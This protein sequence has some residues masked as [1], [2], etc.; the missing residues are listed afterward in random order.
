MN[1]ASVILASASARRLELLAQIGVSCRVVPADIDESRRQGEAPEDYV[2]RLAIAKA[3]AV[4]DSH[5][6]IGLPVLGAD[7]TVVVDNDIFGKPSSETAAVAM[8]QR[9]SG[10]T[11]RVLSAVAMV[12]TK[13]VHHRL[14]ETQVRF[15][16]L[17]AQEC[18]RY[19][20]TAEPLG[21]AGGY[22]IQGRGAVFV[23]AIA[24][25]YSGVVGLPLTETYEL[26]QLFEISCWMGE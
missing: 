22:A 1:D 11:H 20:A 24:G 9:L 3:Q 26:L 15:R 6:E 8:L 14:S 21:K 25:S 18:R 4:R 12:G 10:A 2:R 7:T 17:T 19:W 16:P 13:G 23:E 5:A